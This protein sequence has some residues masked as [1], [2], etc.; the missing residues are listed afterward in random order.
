M[1]KI[2]YSIHE[3][4]EKQQHLDE[5]KMMINDNCRTEIFGKRKNPKLWII[6][7]IFFFWLF[8]CFD[9][10]NNKTDNYRI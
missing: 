6:K 1:N 8:G 5:G 7:M 9:F 3:N 4:N 2:K 10:V